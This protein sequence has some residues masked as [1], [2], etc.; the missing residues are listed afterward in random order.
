MMGRLY[1]L[2]KKH[3]YKIFILFLIIFS[4]SLGADGILR[5]IEIGGISGIYNTIVA[6]VPEQWLAV[7]QRLRMPLGIMLV[8]SLVVF[9][10]KKRLRVLCHISL[11]RGMAPLASD[12]KKEYSIKEKKLDLTRYSYPHDLHQVIA[13]Q[14]S[15]IKDFIS[16]KGIHSYYGIAHTP[17]IFRAGYMYG[18]QQEIRLYHKKRSNNAN[19]E[20]WDTSADVDKW[21]TRFKDVKEENKSCKSNNLIV[22][23]STS[24]EIKN[25][26]I[27]SVTNAKCHMIK[28]QLHTLGFDVIG[29]YT[30]AEIL[31]KQILSK[32]REMVK[33]YDIR[34]IH[35][36]ISS[37]VAFTFFLGAGFSFQHD[38]DIIV[39]HYENGRY[40]WGIDMKKSGTSSVII[41]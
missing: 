21:E 34:C 25:V 20:E 16:T 22:S 10:W 5:K 31:R 4:I 18:D 32:I 35:M 15:V 33:Q 39:Y 8:M 13:E 19:F 17:L 30:Q 2:Y 23:I 40:I 11:A 6:I 27:E 3:Y 24:L 29:N 37:S 9:M 38:P 41:H 28:F 12:V 36:V 14:D 26:E 1:K 7:L